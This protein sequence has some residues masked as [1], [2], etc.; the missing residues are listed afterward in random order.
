MN[1]PF[2]LEMLRHESTSGN[3][4]EFALWLQREITARLHCKVQ[5]QEVG[6]GTLNLLCT[7]GDSP[8][9]CYCTHLD[10]V[11]PYIAPSA[12]H[13][14]A[15]TIVAGRGS[16]DAKGQ[17]LAIMRAC[18]QLEQQ[19][20]TRHAMLLVAGEE[21][22]SH[23]A[24]AFNRTGWG[25]GTLVVCEPTQGK[26]VA[27]SKGTAAFAVEIAGK[28]CHSGYPEHGRSAVDTFVDLMAHLRGIRWATHPT[29]GATTW[30]V[31]KLV[32]DNA[33]NV[34]SDRLSCRIYFRTT[35]AS[36]AQVTAEMMA[37]DGHDG[38]AVAPLGGDQP[39]TYHTLPGMPSTT[40]AFGSDAPQ[41]QH[42]T[43]RMIVGAGSILVAHR[44]QEHVR[45][46]EI[47]ALQDTLV[48]IYGQCVKNVN[49]A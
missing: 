2:F 38:I 11:P 25:C 8:R 43:R 20:H 9:V 37:L 13:N 47:E 46:S 1:L 32:S 49:G 39:L 44:P 12:T 42:F 28:S 40:V 7:W 33:Q 17:I 18:R 3:E 21:T 41:L 15:D 4:R 48:Q 36:A 19:G 34:L 29:M 23:G 14:G 24:K 31:G 10:T 45:W 30:N 35:S 26:L 27:A 5:A 6:D 16:C 22:G